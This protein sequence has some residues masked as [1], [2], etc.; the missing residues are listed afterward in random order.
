[1][2]N[3][4]IGILAHVDAGKTTLSEQILFRTGA[5]RALGRVDHG[6]TALDV[7]PIERERGITVFSDQAVFE[8]GGH[9]YTLIDTPGIGMTASDDARVKKILDGGC[10]ILSALF[11]DADIQQQHIKDFFCQLFF[12]Y[13]TTTYLPLKVTVF[14]FRIFSHTHVD[15]VPWPLST[16]PP[17]G[18]F[19]LPTP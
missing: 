9:R 14:P 2:R 17:S 11:R 13:S 4:T 3:R 19:I 1:M 18:I 7:D 5:V 8:H 6:D 15:A 10:E 16:K 12:S